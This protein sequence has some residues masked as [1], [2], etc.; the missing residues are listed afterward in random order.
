MK[1]LLLVTG[2]LATGKSTFASKL[3]KRYGIV[4][5]YKDQFKEALGDTIGFTNRE[6]NLRLSVASAALMRMLFRGFCAVSSDL[7]L[8][9]NFRQPELEALHKIAQE[10]GYQVLTLVLRADLDVLYERFVHRLYYE[11]RHRVHASGGMEEYDT[12]VAYV[13]G[14]RNLQVPGKS[15]LV[16]ADDFAYQEDSILLNQVDS[17]MKA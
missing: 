4:A 7:I 10:E 12:F 6:E 16:Q 5:L 3:G 15:I 2:D 13:T 14:Q 9:S 11:N 1:K 8:E 17:F